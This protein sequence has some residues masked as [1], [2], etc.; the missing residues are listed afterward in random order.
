[1][2]IRI[3]ERAAEELRRINVKNIR[4]VLKGYG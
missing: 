2:D 1:M 4:I 3:T